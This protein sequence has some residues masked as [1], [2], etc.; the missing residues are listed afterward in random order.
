MIQSSMQTRLVSDHPAYRKTPR[1]RKKAWQ[2][3]ERPWRNRAE[4]SRW[5][6]WPSPQ[7]AQPSDPTITCLFSAGNEGMT[8]INHPLWFPLRESPGSFPHS[9]L[10]TS[11]IIVGGCQTY[12]YGLGFLGKYLDR[13]PNFWGKVVPCCLWDK[14]AKSTLR[15]MV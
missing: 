14:I 10:S 5:E 12:K 7:G 6:G 11:Q 9:L 4:G 8:P 13:G 1:A 15:S 2:F 3:V